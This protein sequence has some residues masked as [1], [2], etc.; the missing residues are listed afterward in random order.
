MGSA[1]P[2]SEAAYQLSLKDY[3]DEEHASSERWWFKNEQPRHRVWV[4]TFYMDKYEVTVGEYDAF[5]RNTGHR[6]LPQ[7]VSTYAPT[8][9]HAVVKV[10]WDDAAAYCQWAEKRLPTEAEWEKAA[11]GEDGRTY[12]WGNT[13]LTGS[14]ANYCDVTCSSA[15]KDS[16][17]NDGYTYT[18][19]VGSYADGQSPYGI[20][21]LAGNVGEWVQDWYETEY[22]RQSADR[23]PV[24]ENPSSFRVLRGGSWYLWSVNLRTAH[25][26]RYRPDGRLHN[27]GFRCVL[28]PPAS[29][30]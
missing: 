13:A 14:R 21:D 26:S 20:Y 29:M 10:S 2:E 17:A 30:P 3:P 5:L 12:P 4:D 6:S 8:S 15:W 27:V 11:R 22:Y 24:N 16:A 18:A 9:N 1:E 25:R 23:N 7:D 19:P 28:A